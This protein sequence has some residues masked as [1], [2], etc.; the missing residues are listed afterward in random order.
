ML[1]ARARRPAPSVPAPTP[2]QPPTPPTSYT[3]GTQGCDSNRKGE[4]GQEEVGR[5]A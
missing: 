3:V 4:V 1:S 2:P 5:E